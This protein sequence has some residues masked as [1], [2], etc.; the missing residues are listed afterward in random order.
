MY[1]SMSMTEHLLTLAQTDLSL[2]GEHSCFKLALIDPAQHIC[3]VM[4]AIG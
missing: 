3:A 4:E 2:R 1:Q